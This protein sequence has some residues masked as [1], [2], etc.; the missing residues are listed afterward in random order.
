MG[1]KRMVMSQVS[2]KFLGWATMWGSLASSR[3]NSRSEPQK[4]ESRDAQS[5]ECGLS[6]K[7]HVTSKYGVVSF[8]GLD[9]FIG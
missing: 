3:K 9:N 8:Y 6:Q 4:S 2:G 1:H 7:V 5:I